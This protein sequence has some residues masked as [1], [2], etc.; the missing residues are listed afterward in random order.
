M[1]DAIELALQYGPRGILVLVIVFLVIIHEKKDGRIMKNL[2]KNFNR[3]EVLEKNDVESDGQFTNIDI[4]LKHL[5]EKVDTI[6]SGVN[7]IV[8][9]FVAEGMKK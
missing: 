2:K 3:I 9:H 6:N 1:I 5:D 4:K 7:K 8:D